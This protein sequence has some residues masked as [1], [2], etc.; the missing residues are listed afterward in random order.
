MNSLF[1]FKIGRL[2]PATRDKNIARIYKSLVRIS[3]RR[4]TDAQLISCASR[5][6]MWLMAFAGA[7]GLEADDPRICDVF[8]LLRMIYDAVMTRTEDPEAGDVDKALLVRAA[9]ELMAL[10]AACKT[11]NGEDGGANGTEVDFDLDFDLDF[12]AAYGGTERGEEEEGDDEGG[13]N[14]DDGEREELKAADTGEDASGEAPD[15]G[16]CAKT[17]RFPDIALR[18]TRYSEIRDMSVPICSSCTTRI[19]ADKLAGREKIENPV[20]FSGTIRIRSLD[21][22]RIELDWTGDLFAVDFGQTVRSEQFAVHNPHVTFEGV[23]IEFEYADFA[24]FDHT[25]AD[26]VRIGDVHERSQKSVYPETADREWEALFRLDKLIEAGRTELYPLKALLSASNNWSTY[27]IVRM[28]QFRDILLEGIARGCL[29]PENEYAWHV[30][31]IAAANNDPGELIPDAESFGRIL[32]RAAAAGNAS[33][34][35]FRD[36][37]LKS[38]T[39]EKTT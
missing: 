33:A 3:K 28:G 31:N 6:E 20:P 16:V 34:N 27:T 37:V 4:D 39:S 32:D 29:A 5:L 14:G 26:I 38:Q 1:R 30:M 13:E 36:L 22:K 18:I 15:R 8:D 21:E 23:S 9:G 7:R 25:V 2:R 35:E 10:D 24:D 12:D 11:D 19:P 17:F